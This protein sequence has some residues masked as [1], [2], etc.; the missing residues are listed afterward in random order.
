MNLAEFSNQLAGYRSGGRQELPD[1][2][3]H[4]DCVRL[5]SRLELLLNSLSEE[6]TPKHR[7]RALETGKAILIELLEF[8]TEHFGP[9]VVAQELP[10]ICELRDLARD[11][12]S[13]IRPGLLSKLLGSKES[14]EELRTQAYR[15]V[16]SEFSQ[17]IRNLLAIV[18]GNFQEHE[19]ANDW[20][21]SCRVFIEDFRRR[22]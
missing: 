1:A 19:T 22:W 7:Y 8:L 5:L 9:E 3:L 18:D 13:L 10:R 16:G 21:G 11:V 20:R 17:V 15:H 12:Q 6:P 2:Q 14:P 4:D